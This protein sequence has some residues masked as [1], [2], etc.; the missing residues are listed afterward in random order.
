MSDDFLRPSA[1]PKR[2]S[3]LRGFL[4]IALVAFLLG[5]AL[6]GW[7]G[8]NGTLDLGFG[9]KAPD[10]AVSATTPASQPRLPLATAPSPSPSTAP[11]PLQQPA[12]AGAFDQRVAALETRL[13]DLSL[14]AEAASGN[15]TR[16][17]GMLIAFAARRALDRGSELGD[18]AGQL[19]L[20]FGSAEPQAV[21]TVLAAAP[22]GL[23]LDKLHAELDRLGPD[24]T[25]SPANESGW[26]RFR[27]EV[28][29]LFEIRRGTGEI[30]NPGER[31]EQAKLLLR[32]GQVRKAR[33]LV[34]T[35]PGK[36]AAADWLAA[37]NRYESLQQALD[38]LELAAL[39][40][41]R[42]LKDA[43]GRKVEQP[44]PV[45]I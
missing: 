7:L 12:L 5:G 43:T 26:G 8:W 38:R 44:S 29:G 30:G 40:D 28:S 4:V 22:Q 25:G 24:L 16:A 2:T 27:R 9:N 39:K 13:A 32:S 14:R 37:A 42:E 41:P 19:Q 18:L 35:L 17:E 15:A 33:E 45:G 23:T 1:P 31:V 11:A 20:R 36:S 10:P 34:E 21:E 6:V 3:P